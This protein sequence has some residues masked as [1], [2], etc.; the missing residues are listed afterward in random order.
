MG[1]SQPK[2]LNAHNKKQ[3]WLLAG[4]DGAGKSTFY[5]TRLDNPFQQ[6]AVIRHGQM[7]LIKEPMPTWT[8]ELIANYSR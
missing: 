2:K 6:I 4:G 1:S 5:K 3:L 8:T 7:S